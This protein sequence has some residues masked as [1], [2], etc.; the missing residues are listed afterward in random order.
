MA[1]IYT[2]SGDQGQTSLVGGAR[3]SKS[4]DRLESYGTVDELNSS[5]GILI[6]EIRSVPQLRQKADRELG[7]LSMI[8][9][10]LFDVGSRLACEDLE[11]QKL[12]PK[13]NAERIADLES[14]ID[15]LQKDLPPLK[16]F[17]LPGG[18][19]A[20]SFCH[21]ARTVCRRAERATVRLE[22]AALPPDPDVLRYLNRL[23]DYLFVLARALNHW[24]GGTETIWSKS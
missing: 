24:S 11:N 21:L 10:T 19:R 8:Q 23:S 20:A 7:L 5:I 17:I 3:V 6:A 4:H 2:K 15:H 18:S 9:N 12:L 16:N 22:H 14:A 13:L 1:K